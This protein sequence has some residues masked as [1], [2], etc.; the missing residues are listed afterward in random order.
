[1]PR[2]PKLKKETMIIS[3]G[4]KDVTVYLHPPTGNRKSW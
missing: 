3:H 4:D 1:M 2:K